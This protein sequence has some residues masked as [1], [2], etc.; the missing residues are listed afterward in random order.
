MFCIGQK[1]KFIAKENIIVSKQR[2]FIAI[3]E[4]FVII[5]PYRDVLLER[6]DLA[7]VPDPIVVV[8]GAFGKGTIDESKAVISGTNGKN[9]GVKAIIFKGS[10]FWIEDNLCRI[11]SRFLYIT[12]IEITEHEN[13]KVDLSEYFKEYGVDVYLKSGERKKLTEDFNP[14]DVLGIFGYEN[15]VISLEYRYLRILQEIDETFMGYKEKDLAF[16]D[17]QG[18]NNTLKLKSSKYKGEALKF[19][20]ELGKDWYIPALGELH[21]VFENLLQVNFTLRYLGKPIIDYALFYSST[22]LDDLSC[23]W[24]CRSGNSISSVSHETSYI[25]SK[26]QILPFYYRP[27]SPESL[28]YER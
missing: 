12:D 27:K 15:Q 10:E 14:E 13:F 26:G 2:E 24:S 9:G 25:T 8:S 23:I 16:T 6:N 17:L 20:E 4:G 5:D 22:T 19:C 3:D 11:A 28:I 21:K 18:Y 1:N 7:V